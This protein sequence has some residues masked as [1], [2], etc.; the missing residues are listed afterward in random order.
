MN[1]DLNHNIHERA[2]QIWE[3]EGRP[4]GRS[5]DHWLQAEL[6]ANAPA[7]GARPPRRARTTKTDTARTGGKTKR[8]PAAR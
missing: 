7:Q 4:E 8:Q 1:A 6:E 5:L 3:Q 2:Y